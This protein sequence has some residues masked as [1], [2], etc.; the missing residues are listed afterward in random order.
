MKALIDAIRLMISEWLISKAL[1][2][3]PEVH[4]D[5]AR[6]AKHM[7]RWAQESITGIDTEQRYLDAI[8]CVEFYAGDAVE[9]PQN[10]T[11]DIEKELNENLSE[12][13][14][15]AHIAKGTCQGC[16][17]KKGETFFQKKVAI[18]NKEWRGN[19]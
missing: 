5:T 2:V 14:R 7:H 19:K 1:T 16:C 13:Y 3:A 17:D 6:L 8:T 12:L 18:M 9:L 15:I 4:P 11:T 10:L